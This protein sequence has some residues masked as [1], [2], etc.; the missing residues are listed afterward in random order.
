MEKNIN[1][2]IAITLSLTMI[3]TTQNIAY[4]SFNIGEDDANISS[5]EELENDSIAFEEESEFATPSIAS[6][7]NA[8]GSFNRRTTAPE[9]GNNYYY[10]RTYNPF[11]PNY[12][13]Q[14]TWYAWGR[15]YEILGYRPNLSIGHASSFY[16]YNSNTGIYPY[17]RE[18]KLGAIACFSA[19]NHAGS[20]GHV[21]VVEIVG[22]DG[23]VA[24]SEYNF[25]VVQGFTS[26]RYLN[27]WQARNWVEGYI[28][29]RPDDPAPPPPP[30]P[31]DHLDPRQE[32]VMIA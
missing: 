10:N 30:S 7:R 20:Y 6:Y 2:I 31:P 29:I 3:F 18:P 17:G 32:E 13:G 11:A 24:L 1:K 27:S 9:W 16:S 26:Y 12:V 28:Y 14:C 23:S 5:E 4:A 22:G 25:N 8:V 15:A 19:N 21:A